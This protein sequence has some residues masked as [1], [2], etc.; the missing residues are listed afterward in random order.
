MSS[1]VQI[2]NMALAHLGQSQFLQSL[3]ERSKAAS[4]CS[5][6]Y[7]P[8]RDLLLRAYDWNFARRR[9]TLA[10]TS[11]EVPNWQYAY[12]YPADCMAIRGLVVKGQRALRSDQ[13]VPYEVATDGDQKLILTDLAEAEIV[14]TA[15]IT[16][17]ALFDETFIN[18]LAYLLASHIAMP[19]VAEPALAKRCA[20]QAEA[21]ASAAIAS[22]LNERQADIEPDCELITVRA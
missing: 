17:V 10:L 7:E 6:F 2:C 20:E 12:R 14:Y 22:D 1:E 18:A 16:N 21:A 13:R 19:M 8:T 9:K 4:V 15:K 5:V 3:T 11:V